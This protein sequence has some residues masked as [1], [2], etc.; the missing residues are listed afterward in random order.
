MIPDIALVIGG[1]N[2]VFAEWR[3]AADLCATY[4]QPYHTFV[5]NSMIGDFPEAMTHAVT[6]H[7]ENLSD[8]LGGRGS[9]GFPPPPRVWSHRPFNSVTDYTRDVQGSVG[10]F[11][12]KVGRQLGYSKFILC[13]VPMTVED[14][15]YKR[16]AR[17]NACT[18]FQKA[19]TSRSGELSLPQCV[20]SMSGWTR[21][22]L[23]FPDAEWMQ[24]AID[25]PPLRPK[26]FSLKA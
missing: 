26:P 20:R 5:C 9:K 3:A 16:K 13:G 10:L 8:W 6:L 22:Q 17:W 12:V 19:W 21:Q 7:P 25:L 24:S 1:S 4:A 2:N 11:A 23:G 14:E 15:H 18:A